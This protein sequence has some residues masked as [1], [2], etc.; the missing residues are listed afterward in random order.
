MFDRFSF[1]TVWGESNYWAVKHGLAKTRDKHFHALKT[2]TCRKSLPG[3][4]RLS[5]KGVRTNTSEDVRDESPH[6]GY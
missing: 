3:R 6:A 4:K 1:T 5:K 2:K